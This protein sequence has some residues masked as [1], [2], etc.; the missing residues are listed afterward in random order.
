[1][2]VDTK[3]EEYDE[4]YDQWERCEHAAEGQDEIHEYG[5]AYLPRLSGQT[6]QE[7]KAY[8]QRALFYNATQRTIDGLTG[9][10]FIKP[11]ITEYPQGLES[12]TADVTM[13][14]VN[15]HQF[16]EMVAEEVVMLGRAG[17]LVDHP[18]MTEALT[19]AQAQEQGMR[20]YMRLYDAESI[21]N[22]RT[23]RIAGVEML[24]LVVLEEEYEIYKD[25]FEYEC[26]EQYRVLDLVNGV[27]RQRVFRKD[28]RGNFYVAETI[29]P[30]SQGRPI[31]RI[32]FEFFGIRDNTPSVDKPPLLDLVD[33]NLSHYRTTAD[34]EHGLHFTGLPTPVVTGFYSDDSS[35]QLRIGSGT[36]WLLPDPSS[37]AFYLE[38]TGQG[39]SELREA[40]RAK[41]A[42]MAT[43]G[44]RILAPERKVSETAQA[45]AIHQ[46]GE[47]SVLASIAQSISIGLTHCLEWMVNWTGLTGLVKV[48]INRVYLPNSLTYQDVQ[49]LVQSWQAGAISHQTLFDNL[50]K[51]DIIAADTN[52]ADELERID[53]NA[54][55]LPPVRNNPPPTA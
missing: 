37:Q 40:L 14:G 48:E 21:I 44:A 20:P 28:E 25:E 36:A 3:H 8:K 34:Y 23:E 13:S 45:A 43:L 51:G 6:D 27:Y 30:T 19:L 9:L 38:F 10:L 12:I 24:V 26:K 7:Y 29:F 54:P 16:A 55:G 18:P 4:H 42:M 35:A 47:N 39:L 22:W 53:L 33:V 31:A 2:A 50:V 52:F 32:P 11:P 1:M 5:V 15:L 46:A 49:A 41:E 17:V